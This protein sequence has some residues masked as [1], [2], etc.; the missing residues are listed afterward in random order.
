MPTPVESLQIILAM[1]SVFFLQEVMNKKPTPKIATAIK[2]PLNFIC[3]DLI[4][5]SLKQI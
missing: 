3:S 4:R 2:I 5:Y 1:Q